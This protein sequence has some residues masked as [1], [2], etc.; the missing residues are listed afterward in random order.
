MALEHKKND[1]LE[2]LFEE[3]AFDPYQEEQAARD[4]QVQDDAEK[5]LKK[6]QDQLAKK[7]KTIDTQPNQNR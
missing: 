4:K 2:K 5:F 3:F 6:E 1:K 7:N